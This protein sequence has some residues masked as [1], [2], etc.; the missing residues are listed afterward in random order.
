MRNWFFKSAAVLGSLAIGL[1]A[2]EKDETKV[3]TEFGAAPVLSVSSSAPLVL[4]QD[5]ADQPALTYTWTPYTMA[6]SDGSTP[7]SPVTYTLQF[8]KAGTKFESLQELSAGS[9]S[10]STLAIKTVDLNTALLGLN[11][12]FTAPSQVDVR[13]KTVVAGNIAPLYSASSTLT[14]TPYDFCEQ[15]AA[16]KA[17]TL[18]GAA[19]QGWGTDIAMKYDCT[20]KTFSYTGPLKADEFK[21]RYGG[22]DPVTGNWKADLGGTSSTG[23][24]LIQGGPNLKIAT[25]GTYTII[26]TPGPLA[27]DGK[28]TNGTFTIK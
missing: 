4:L 2:C 16:S 14:V 23:G 3:T 28:A 24:A 17:W 9:G 5:N 1:T 10:T 26:L 21:F 27:A 11:L 22:T 20:S 8:A 15:P 19:A 13:L 25:A 12:P 18:I 7:V 6:L